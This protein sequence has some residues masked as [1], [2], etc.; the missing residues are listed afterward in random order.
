MTI[1]VHEILYFP[2]HQGK[3]V[4]SNGH[5]LPETKEQ[6]VFTAFAIYQ[7][8]NKK[9]KHPEKNQSNTYE[10]LGDWHKTHWVIRLDKS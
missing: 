8:N 6:M 1:K 2:T 5:I 9:V 4:N 10:Q 3:S 7:E